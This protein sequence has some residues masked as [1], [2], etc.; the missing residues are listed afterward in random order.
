MPRGNIC[1]F[2]FFMTTEDETKARVNNKWVST[3]SL[4]TRMQL[5]ISFP[6]KVNR[7]R[8]TAILDANTRKVVVNAKDSV[9]DSN[10]GLKITRIEWLSKL[11]TGKLYGS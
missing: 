6:V 9:S 2:V 5:S 3:H 4:E 8:A 7:V 11:G 1:Y 10:G